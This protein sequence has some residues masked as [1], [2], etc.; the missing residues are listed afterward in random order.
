MHLRHGA[1]ALCET[2]QGWMVEGSVWLRVELSGLTNLDHTRVQKLRGHAMGSHT[3]VFL[4]HHRGYVVPLGP[5]LALLH[6]PVAFACTCALRYARA[7]HIANVAACAGL[8]TMQMHCV[9]LI[10]CDRPSAT[11][12]WSRELMW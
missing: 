5:W 11:S 10:A 6:A 8:A 7:H 2:C 3:R 12:W 4:L 1:A 9:I